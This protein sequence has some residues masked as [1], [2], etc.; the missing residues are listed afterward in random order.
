MLD[1]DAPGLAFRQHAQGLLLSA[2]PGQMSVVA[3]EGKPLKGSF[4]YFNEQNVAQALS[5]FPSDA[6]ILLGYTETD[7]KSNETPV[8]Q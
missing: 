5:A 6:A 4:D 2:D 7:V 1:R 8:A 3:L